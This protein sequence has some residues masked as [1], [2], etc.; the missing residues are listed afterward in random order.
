MVGQA[1]T[2]MGLVEVGVG[3]IP[4]G[5]GCLQM[6]LRLEDALNAKGEKGPMPKVKAAFQL[7]GTA[8]VNT[9]FDE[10]QRQGYF[11][12]TDRR[13]MNTQHLLYEAKQEV[14]SM[15]IQF[16]PVTP[17]SCIFQGSAV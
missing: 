11:R 8:H 12:R 15:A 7:I 4:A 6:L 14:L 1:E 13:V 2:Y 10:A 16:K 17:A 9:S 3:V 5:G